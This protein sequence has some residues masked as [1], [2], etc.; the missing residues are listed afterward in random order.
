MSGNRK[1]LTPGNS[2]RTAGTIPEGR[3]FQP[4]QSGNPSGRPKGVASAFRK[5]VD[6]EAAAA[7]LLEIAESAPKPE[8]RIAA[9]RELLDR[10]YGKAPAFAAME[11]SDPLEL[12]AIAGEIQ[13]I[14]DELRERDELR[15]RR[16]EKQAASG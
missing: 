10:G 12:G 6:P 2:G 4:G 11:G 16:D 14:A 7:S 5:I 13:A 15:A 3:R 1:R 9:W 8:Q